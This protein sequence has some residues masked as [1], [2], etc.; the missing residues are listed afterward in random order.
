[1]LHAELHGK[2]DPRAPDL[3]R[4]E[5][6]L[7]S[8]TFGTLLIAHSTDLLIA[9]LNR[10]RRLGPDGRL[11]K[12]DFGL[13]DA[14]VAF[15]FWPPL[16]NVQP[17]LV[18]RIGSRL[19]LIEAKYESRKGGGSTAE[20]DSTFT[21][22]QLVREWQAIQSNATGIEWYPADLRTAIQTTE[23][24]LIYLVSARRI[25]VARREVRQSRDQIRGT[26]GKEPAMWLLTWQ[27]LHEVLTRRWNERPHVSSWV[28]DLARLLSE[29]RQLAAFLGFGEASMRFTS[30]SETI[31]AWA[32]EWRKTVS[33]GGFGVLEALDVDELH[34]SLAAVLAWSATWKRKVPRHFAQT[35]TGLDLDAIHQVA[36]HPWAPNSTGWSS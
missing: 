4:R 19:I 14:P 22:D 34:E 21:T 32:D 35:L 28:F 1:V 5:D 16:G 24:Q 27:D 18:L 7:T 29:R 31:R 11:L 9:W 36:A 25:A 33:E 6:V 13:E 17:D 8:T 20:T 10:A 30:H 12:P 2:L 15:W 3:E 26:T 23:P